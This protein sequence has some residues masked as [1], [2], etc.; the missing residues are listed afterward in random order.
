VSRRRG[1][2]AAFAVLC[3]LCAAVV[4]VVYARAAARTEVKAK[5]ASSVVHSEA[6]AHPLAAGRLLVRSTVLDDTFG[7]VAVM[8]LGQPGALRTTTS[9]VCERVHF[10]AGRGICLQADSDWLPRWTGIIVDSRLRTLR[11]FSLAGRPSRARMAPSGRVAAYTVFVNGHAYNPGGFSTRTAVVDVASGK[12]IANLEKFT[13]RRDGR[14]LRSPDFNVWGVT[15]AGDGNR[16]YAT[17]GT[18]G[19]TYLVEGDLRAR[20]LEV[21]RDGV[22]CPSL[23]PNGARIAFK[24]R[25]NEG[26]TPTWRIAVLELE[27]LSDTSLAETRNVDDQL[28]WLDDERVAYGLPS[29]DGSTGGDLWAVRADGS[30]RP[31]RLLAGAASPAAVRG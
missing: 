26:S 19:H 22:E 12:E 16:F 23:S 25:S 17:L 30:G 24:Q 5:R 13:V 15:F 6:L 8:R 20:E 31:V 28:E 1:R 29:V 2:I 11:T 21:L 14:V 4:A 7:R 18:D 9:L 3:A 27:T 10:A